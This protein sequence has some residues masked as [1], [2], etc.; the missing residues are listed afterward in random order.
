MFSLVTSTRSLT[1]ANRLE[2]VRTRPNGGLR[3]PVEVP[4][5]GAGAVQRPGQV[6]GQRFPA[7]QQ[8]HVPLLAGW[9]AD[10]VR[11]GVVLAKQKPTAQS[12]ADEA[13]KRFGEQADAILKAYPAGTDAEALESAAALASDLFIGEATWK[14]IEMHSRT[15][16]SPE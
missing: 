12:F 10:E 9:N 14:W 16:A 1:L 11:G 7:G 4:H 3:R 2:P 5:L 15:G 6:N 13:R 8:A